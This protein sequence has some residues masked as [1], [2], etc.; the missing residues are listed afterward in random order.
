MRK[1]DPDIREWMDLEQ[2]VS[3]ELELDLRNLSTLNRLFGSHSLTLRFMKRWLT[4][5]RCWR[6]LDLATGAG[7]IPRLIARYA[8]NQNLDVQI[9]AV[10]AQASTLEVAARG[11]PENIQ[12]HQADIREFGGSDQW[13]IV[14]CSLALHHFSREDA[15][16]ILKRARALAGG[17][18]LVSDLRRSALGTLGVDL[19]TSVW[20]TNAMTRNDARLSTRRA[21]SFTE[22]RDLA[23]DAGW[24][25]YGHARFFC[26]RQAVWL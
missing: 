6:I 15:I 8:R 23:S 25:Q 14:L 19:L 12:F 16:A 13:D 2:P 24:R 9:D 10:D 21:F 4:P 17:H 7:D 5:G 20:M 11:T 18:V 26:F 22:L 3:P 1:F